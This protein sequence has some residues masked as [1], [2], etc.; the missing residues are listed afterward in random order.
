[1]KTTDIRHQHDENGSAVQKEL[2]RARKVRAILMRV[3]MALTILTWILVAFFA[4]VPQQPRKQPYGCLLAV[5]V[6]VAAPETA[7][8]VT[9]AP[10]A[11][12]ACRTV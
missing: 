5:A 1:M 12:G 3:L 9:I 6:A 2:A 7:T 4:P 8:P 11:A 10:I